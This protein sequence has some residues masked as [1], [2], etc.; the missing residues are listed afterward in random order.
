MLDLNFLEALN[1]L[2]KLNED[3]DQNPAESAVE[4]GDPNSL[5]D[6][7]AAILNGKNAKK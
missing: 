4:P 5:A 3:I 7:R 2:D 1:K 6:V